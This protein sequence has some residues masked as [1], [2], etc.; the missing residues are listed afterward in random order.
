MFGNSRG[1]GG[2]SR[3]LMLGLPA[4]L[5]AVIGVALI[6]TAE[7]GV[8]KNL[9]ERYLSEAEKSTKEKRR[10]VDELR[11]ELRIRRVAAPSSAQRG[12][13]LIPEDLSLIHI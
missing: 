6:C 5:V 4:V 2:R 10:L 3:A 12:E 1:Q 9:E 13:Q 8:A 11:R 7:F